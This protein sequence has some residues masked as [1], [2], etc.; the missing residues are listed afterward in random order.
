MQNNSTLHRVPTIGGF[1]EKGG[2]ETCAPPPG[3]FVLDLNNF[4]L[5]MGF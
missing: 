5:F 1:G 4:C 2:T 3:R